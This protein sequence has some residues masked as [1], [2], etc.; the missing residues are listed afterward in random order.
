[1]MARASPFD[2]QGQGGQRPD[3]NQRGLGEGWQGYR[4]D[5]VHDGHEDAR[6]SGL[7]LP[8]FTQAS[9]VRGQGVGRGDGEKLSWLR[10]CQE[11]LTAHPPQDFLCL[12]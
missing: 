3:P 11:G 5:G 8:Q 1:M 2:Q 6:L 10:V 7:R 9:E 12:G 4:L